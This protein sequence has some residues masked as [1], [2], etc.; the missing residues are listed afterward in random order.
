LI[1]Y[2]TLKGNLLEKGMYF[3]VKEKHIKCVA[4]NGSLF[5]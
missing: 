1:Q 3:E 5:G 2:N 4:E